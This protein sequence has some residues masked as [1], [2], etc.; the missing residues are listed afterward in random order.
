MIVVAFG[1]TPMMTD[2]EII[3]N[4]QMLPLTNLKRGVCVF[5]NFTLLISNWLKAILNKISIKL[6]VSTNICGTF[7]P[8][9]LIATTTSASP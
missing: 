3:H 2:N 1:S 9:I 7:F 5:S 4:G 8:D 6:P